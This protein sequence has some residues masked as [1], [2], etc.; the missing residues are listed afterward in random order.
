MAA[1]TASAAAASNTTSGRRSAAARALP[2]RRYKRATTTPN[3]AL[4]AS[5][6]ALAGPLAR[7]QERRHVFRALRARSVAAHGGHDR[8][9]HQQVPLP[10]EVL[11]V[12]D[13][14]PASE[15]FHVPTHG[16]A[17]LRAGFADGARRVVALDQRVDEEAALEVVA[18]EPL[19]EDVEDGKQAF[20]GRAGALLDRGDEPAFGPELLAPVEDGERGH[21][22]YR[23]GV[24]IAA[25]ASR[26]GLTPFRPGEWRGA[27]P[28]GSDSRA[29]RAKLGTSGR[30]SLQGVRQLRERSTTS[31]I[32]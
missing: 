25:A 8:A 12:R 15:L 26:I 29:W 1:A 20:L 32:R 22:G 23:D 31:D 7:E 18:V 14:Y 24:H 6:P 3:G 16:L 4:R 2:A 21:D 17:L 27:L 11:G 30:A 19:G 28:R 10:G 9:L 13:P 5:L